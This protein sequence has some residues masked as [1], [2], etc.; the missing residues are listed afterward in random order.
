VSFRLNAG[1]VLFVTGIHWP[2][3]KSTCAI[4]ANDCQHLYRLCSQAV[5]RSETRVGE[6]SPAGRGGE[7]ERALT[8]LRVTLPRTFE[9]MRNVCCFR[10]LYLLLPSA[11]N[12]LGYRLLNYAAAIGSQ[13]MSGGI[14]YGEAS[15]WL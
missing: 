3:V 1:L 6:K 5:W 10:A 9:F 8:P 7:I 4:D 13:E 2:L 14:I 11:F 12:C 15:S